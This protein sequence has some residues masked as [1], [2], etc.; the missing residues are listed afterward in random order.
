[1]LADFIGDREV[2]AFFGQRLAVF[3]ENMLDELGARRV[4][5]LVRFLVQINVQ[6]SGDWV[7]AR[8]GRFSGRIV[9]FC[10]IINQSISK[11]FFCIDGVGRE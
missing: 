9:A 1:M 7:F 4:K 2:P 10:A 3:G 8:I 5:R 6:V 11:F